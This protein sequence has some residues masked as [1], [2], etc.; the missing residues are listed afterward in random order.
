MGNSLILWYS[1]G[2]KPREFTGQEMMKNKEILAV[3][4]VVVY[5]E[6][7]VAILD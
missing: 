6:P 5:K 2:K 7:G 1:R 4:Q 3:L